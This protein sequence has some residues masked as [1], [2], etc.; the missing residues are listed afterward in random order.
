MLKGPQGTLFG[1]NTAAGAISIITN[2]PTDQFEGNARIRLGEYGR[3][4]G[5]ALLNVPVNQDLAL[6][7]SVLDNQSNGYLREAVTGQHYG[8]DDEWGARAVAR[9]QVTP[10]STVHLSWDHDRLKQPSRMDIGLIPLSATD[11]YQ[12]APF[13]ADP[14]TLYNPIHA[15]YFN[16]AAGAR[17]RRQ[18]NGC[19]LT[20]DPAFDAAAS[21]PPPTTRPT[22]SPTSRTAT[23]PTTSPPTWTPA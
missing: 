16:D 2:E 19:T 23:A 7:L 20:F 13:P 3:R 14:A 18:Y 15:P 22:T 12:R 9:W 10:D 11:L 8:K 5:D 6:R 1:R 21:P 4:Y 17:E